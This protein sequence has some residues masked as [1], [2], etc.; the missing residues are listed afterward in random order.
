MKGTNAIALSG[1]RSVAL[2]TA[3]QNYGYRC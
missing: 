1:Y 2:S 3:W